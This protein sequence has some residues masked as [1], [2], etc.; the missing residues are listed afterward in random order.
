MKQTILNTIEDLVS[1]FVY[2]DRKEDED[3]SQE[4][5]E[6]AVKTGVIT[7]DEIIEKFAEKIKNSLGR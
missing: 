5:L 2:Y 3:L 1:N 4:D 6:Q 7:V